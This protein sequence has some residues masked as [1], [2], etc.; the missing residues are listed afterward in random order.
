VRKRERPA[1]LIIHPRDNVAVAL[2]DLDPGSQVDV[3][4]WGRLRR[5]PIRDPIPANHKVALARI[6]PGASVVK[7]GAPIGEATAPIRPGAHVHIHNVRSR[8]IR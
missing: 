6:G 2:R 7:Y 4:V 5:I 8:R 3:R 1:V